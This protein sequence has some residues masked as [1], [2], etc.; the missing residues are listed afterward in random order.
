MKKIIAVILSLSF[1]LGAMSVTVNAADSFDAP[2]IE[3]IFEDGVTAEVQQRVVAAIKGEDNTDASTYGLTCTL[4]G[5]K[6]E[7]GT[8][9]EIAHEAK[10]NDPRCLQNTYYYEICT[11]CDYSELTL[12]SSTYI[13]C[14]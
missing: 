13:S 2:H 10:A 8:S 9:T 6:L 4:F 12:L 5:H 7:T 11:R 14:C 1:I 3:Y